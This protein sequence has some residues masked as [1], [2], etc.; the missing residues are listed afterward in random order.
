MYKIN[1]D[2]NIRQKFATFIYL[3]TIAWLIFSSIVLFS[4]MLIFK[5]LY[6]RIAYIIIG[7]LVTFSLLLPSHSNPQ[8][9]YVRS[10]I[11]FKTRYKR[12]VRSVDKADTINKN[13]D[14]E[15][16]KKEKELRKRI[17]KTTLDYIDFLTIKDDKFIK[18]KDGTFIE[19][20][21]IIP[22]NLNNLTPGEKEKLI[23]KNNE[24]YISYSN[25]IKIIY[26]NYPNNF[27]SQKNFLIS[28]INQETNDFK[29]YML[30]LK[31]E[32]LTILEDFKYKKSFFLM[33]FGKS[34]IDLNNNLKI[35]NNNFPVETRQTSSEVKEK[36]L[37]KLNNLNTNF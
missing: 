15:S 23:K 8:K 12:T 16:I 33:V 14:K 28:L 19:I 21:E 31:L 6:F 3:D 35:I 25:D 9:N 17:K 13:K 32:E 37:F 1:K 10:I 11:F 2:I 30:N 34:E 36:I 22:K 4:T 24:F 7:E 27:E 29:K 5:K 20:L 18:H 26:L